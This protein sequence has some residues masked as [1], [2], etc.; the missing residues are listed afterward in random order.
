[1]EKKF[2][3]GSCRSF[4]RGTGGSGVCRHYPPVPMLLPEQTIGGTQLVLRSFF[5][6]VSDDNEACGQYVPAD[7][8]AAMPAQSIALPKH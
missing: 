2:V 3:C 4:S 8:S 7:A 1:M 5:P 6:P